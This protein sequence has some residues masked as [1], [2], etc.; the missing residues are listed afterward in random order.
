MRPCPAVP[1]H[2]REP[3]NNF[4]PDYG[5]IIA[6]RGAAGFGMR[7]DGGTAYSG[8]VVTRLY[9]PLAGESH[10]L[11][12]DAA[13]SHRPNGSGA[14][15]NTAFAAS[16]PIWPSWKRCCPI[17]KFLANDYTTRFI[18]ETPELFHFP[19]RRDRASKLLTY[20]AEVTVNGHPGNAGRARPPADGAQARS[21]QFPLH[22][23]AEMAR[24]QL[25]EELGRGEIRRVDARREPRA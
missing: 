24:K 2:H 6:Y 15:A 23:N 4:I 22:P 20:V 11:G 19:A 5:R 13:G 18:D 17:R 10:R 12:A 9:D 3:E 8:A 21:A 1:H 25:L 14:C 7:I 16:P